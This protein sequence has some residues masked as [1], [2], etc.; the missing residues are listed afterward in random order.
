MTQG[1]SLKKESKLIH[2]KKIVTLDELALSW[3]LLFPIRESNTDIC[4]IGSHVPS[5]T[6]I[7]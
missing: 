2:R 1:N 5:R 4:S 6:H 7:P 3:N